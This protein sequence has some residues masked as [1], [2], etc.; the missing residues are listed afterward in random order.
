MKRRDN[1][2]NDSE[3]SDDTLI[4]QDTSIT[5]VSNNSNSEITNGIE[6]ITEKDEKTDH[7]KVTFDIGDA[8]NIDLTQSVTNSIEIDEKA[9]KAHVSLHHENVKDKAAH[10]Y[11]NQILDGV[12]SHS[13]DCSYSSCFT[14]SHDTEPLLNGVESIKFSKARNGVE[15]SQVSKEAKDKSIAHAKSYPTEISCDKGI[16]CACGK[17]A[18]DQKN[19]ADNNVKSVTESYIG[20]K[21]SYRTIRRV[22]VVLG[23]LDLILIICV[24]TVVPTVVITTSRAPS[25]WTTASPRDEDPNGYTICFDCADL[26]KDRAFSAETLR[27]VYRRDGSCCFKSI[28]SVYFSIKQVRTFGFYLILLNP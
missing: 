2:R 12:N 9:A 27:G 14:T 19:N 17:N 6:T 20:L 25:P 22:L 10:V 5:N 23:I 16:S 7:E 28:T 24:L 15:V 8:G 3:N 11:S 18:R 13:C 1:K 21:T 4:S 26:D